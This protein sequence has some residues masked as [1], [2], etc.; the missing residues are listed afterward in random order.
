[1]YVRNATFVTGRVHVRAVMPDALHGIASGAL[2][3]TLVTTHVV[4]WDDAADALLAHD[5]TKL[6][7]TRAAATG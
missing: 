6:V 5:W 4:D 2:D 3:P 7:F 1:M